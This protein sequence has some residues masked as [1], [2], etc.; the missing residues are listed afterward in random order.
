MRCTRAQSILAR[1][2]ARGISADDERLLVEHLRACPECAGLEDEL[3][4]TWSALECHPLVK[5]S[6]DFVPRLKAKLRA[7][8]EASPVLWTWRP[9]R[10]WQW[11][12]AAACILLATVLLTRNGPLRHNTQPA[13]QELG[14]AA[15]DRDRGDEKIL[16]DLE[17]TL[18]YSDADYLS[19]Y[20]LWPGSPRETTNSA[21]P[22]AGLNYKTKRK[23]SS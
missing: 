2:A 9:D 6:P 14:M 23:E 10:K 13:N 16:Q 17:Q 11:L 1:K 19:A 3:E 5:P 12:A 18:E 20:D 15:A 22:K 8:R 21:P 7:E 4:R